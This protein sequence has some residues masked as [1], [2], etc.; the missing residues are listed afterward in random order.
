MNQMS[1][2]TS[3]AG[4]LPAQAPVRAPATPARG[5]SGATRIVYLA[6]LVLGLV[7]PASASGTG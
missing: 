7:A 6:L 2:S 4:E 3:T 1:P 5:A